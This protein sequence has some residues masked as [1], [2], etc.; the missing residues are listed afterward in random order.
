MSVQTQIDRIAAA[1]ASIAG[2]I[3]DKGVSVPASAKIDE[4]AG[5]VAQI[6]VGIKVRLL[7]ENDSPGTFAAQTLALGL[8]AYDMY[9]IITAHTS[10]AAETVSHITPAGYGTSLQSIG[11]IVGSAYVGSSTTG[12]AVRNVTYSAGSLVFGDT[13][14]VDQVNNDYVIPLYVY[15]I[16]GVA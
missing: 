11:S 10:D 9:V 7:W 4:L 12:L 15:G 6:E 8:D 3:T 5:Y 2:A 1:K 16:T 14:I 13:M